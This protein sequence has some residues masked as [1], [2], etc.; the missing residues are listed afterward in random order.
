MPLDPNPSTCSSPRS[1]ASS[2][3]GC[4]RSR[5]GW[6]RR[7]RCPPRWSPRCGSWGCSGSPSP[8]NMAGS[9]STMS[10]EVRVALELGRTTPAFRSVFGTNVGIGSQGLVMAGSEAQKARMAAAHRQ[11]RDDHQ[12][13]LTEPGAGSDSASVQTRAVRDG[14]VYRLTRHQALHHQCRQGVAVHGDGADRRRGGEGRLRL[15]GAR[16]PAGAQHRQAG[17]EDGPAGRPCLRRPS[18]TRRP[19][20]PPT[21]SARKARGSGSRCGCSTAAGCTSPRSASGSP[22]G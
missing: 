2:P 16:R 21:G 20:R 12:L 22:S 13:R 5:R 10:E 4:G 1:A 15:P 11:R 7:T 14:D 8:R 17:A 3:S 6:P 9:A 19:S 18:S